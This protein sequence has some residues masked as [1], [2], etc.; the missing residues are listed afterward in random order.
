MA[1]QTYDKR[2]FPVSNMRRFLEPGPI[3]L[4]S[5]A[6]QGRDQHH[7]HG[8]AHDHGV[9]ALAGRL[10]HL[11]REPQFDWCAKARSASLTSQPPT[12]RRRWSASATVRAATSTNSR[13][14]GSTAEKAQKSWRRSFRSATP[15][16]NAGSATRASSTS[17]VCSSGR[18]S[19]PT[20][21]NRRTYPR[22]L[23]YRG[24]GEF[25]ISGTNTRRYRRLFKP[26]M[27]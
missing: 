14:S 24:D 27:L 5:S 21:R 12:W 22:T 18:S 4:V 16:S 7:D 3:V 10:L 23:H 25:M 15:T 2:D 6:L 1:A 9:R 19:R 17:T 20:W 8:L 13:S 26:E 11:E